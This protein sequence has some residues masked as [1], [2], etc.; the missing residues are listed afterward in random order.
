MQPVY[1]SV[2]DQIKWGGVWW[3]FSLYNFTIANG[4]P[5]D[6]LR[7]LQGVHVPWYEILPI[8]QDRQHDKTVFT[9]NQ[10]ND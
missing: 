1:G 6:Y 9:A 4:G 10:M 8:A 7:L 5:A 3:K 2:S